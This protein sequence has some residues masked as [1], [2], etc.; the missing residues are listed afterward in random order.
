MAKT[1]SIFA[2]FSIEIGGEHVSAGSRRSPYTMS[3]DGEKYDV[4]KE[5]TNSSGDNYNLQTLWESGDG[6]LSD[7]DFLWLVSDADGYVTLHDTG[8][9]AELAVFVEANVPFMLAGDDIDD[10]EPT[11]GSAASVQVCDKI[12]FFNSGDGTSADVDALVRLTLI[13]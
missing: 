3:V 13:T 10:A 5:I 1:L 2:G 4:V 8:T 11:D 12:T 6:G 9:S 7:F